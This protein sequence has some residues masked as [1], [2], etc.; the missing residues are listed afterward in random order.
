LKTDDLEEPQWYCPHCGFRESIWRRYYWRCPR[1]GRPLKILFNREYRPHGKGLS[2][3]SSM[4]PFKPLKTIGEG[5]TPLVELDD[6]GNSLLFKLE[7]MNPSGSFK[8]RGTLISI[9]YAYRMGYREVVED[10]SGNTGISVALYSRVFG[11]KSLIIMPR[12]APM[13]K[14]KLVK[15]L[16]GKIIEASD[17]GEASRIVGVFINDSRYYVA[18][19]W[20][21]FYVLGASTISFEVFD[22]GYIPDYVVIPLGSGGLFLGLMSGFEYLYSSGYIEKM[23]KPLIVEGYS[24]Q[25]LHEALYGYRLE[26]PS[27]SLADGIMVPNPPRLDEIIEYTRKYSGRIILV[28]NNEIMNASEKL[29]DYGFIVEPTSATVY[30][31]Y[32]KLREELRGKTILLPLTGSGLKII[33]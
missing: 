8:D 5:S 17:R 15:Y 13:G 6:H 2:R 7:Y 20:S 9:S 12:N 18:H 26:G 22:E 27:S 30:A 29:L 10:T 21:Y 28:G 11:L 32:E 3:Y 31:A 33:S 16:G 23:P 14:K 24:V 1:C 25:P 19:T 4:L